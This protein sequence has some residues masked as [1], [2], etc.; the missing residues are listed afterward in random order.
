MLEVKKEEAQNMA[1]VLKMKVIGDLVKN[2][3]I[4]IME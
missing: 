4:E 1:I 2:C 3:F